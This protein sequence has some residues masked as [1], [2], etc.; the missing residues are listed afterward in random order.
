MIFSIYNARSA[1]E[2]TLAL[3]EADKVHP[4]TA[5]EVGR[6]LLELN[7]S[8]E[9][10][11]PPLDY[12]PPPDTRFWIIVQRYDPARRTD[13]LRGL[14]QVLGLSLQQTR[15]CMAVLDVGWETWTT[16]PSSSDYPLAE[17]VRKL[18]LDYGVEAAVATDAPPPPATHT[19]HLRDLLR[20]PTA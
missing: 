12:Q 8:K 20:G 7:P 3:A 15:E 5:Y 2:I 14:R 17:Q 4:G 13:A 16:E 11:G 1:G 19:A 18:S 6:I 9:I 10:E